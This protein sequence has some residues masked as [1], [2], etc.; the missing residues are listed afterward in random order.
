MVQ[1]NQSIKFTVAQLGDLNRADAEHSVIIASG[2]QRAFEFEMYPKRF[3]IDVNRYKLPNTGLDL[4]TAAQDVLR[5]FK[6]PRP[7]ILLTSHPYSDS[8]YGHKSEYFFYAGGLYNDDVTIISSY[9]WDNL[10]GARPL[11][12]YLLFEFADLMLDRLTDL[13]SHSETRGCLFDY[14]DDPKDIDLGFENGPLCN[15]CEQITYKELRSGMLSLEQLASVR[16]LYNRAVGKKV[17]FV[18][19]PFKRELRPTYDAIS[20]A[21]KDEHWTVI[22]ADEIGRP[23]RITDAIMQAILTSDLV[24]ADLTGTNPNVFYELGAAHAIGCD[25]ILLTQETSIP[26]DVTTEQTI[27]YRMTKRGIQELTQ[28]VRRLAGSGRA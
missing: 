24:V 25:V 10:P 19:M 23:R 13:T 14:C 12:P 22:R 9:L 2:V 21:L 15:S 3:P 4:E 20:S 28:T 17:C 5:R 1:A 11:Q 6:W 8:D 16:K 18:V 27:F 7:L 26:F